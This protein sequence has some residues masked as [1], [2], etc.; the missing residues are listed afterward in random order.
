MKFNNTHYYSTSDCLQLYDLFSFFS[1]IATSFC[2]AFSIVGSTVYTRVG[3]YE[4]FF[5]ELVSETE[6]EKEKDS[7]AEEDDDADDEGEKKEEEEEEDYD[8]L[9]Y[10]ELDKLE[11]RVLQKEDLEKLGKVVVREKTP[12]GEVI[13]T[14]N[15]NTGSFEY[16]CDDKTIKYMVLD[17]VARKF[18]IDNNCKSICINYKAEFEKARVAIMAE[19]V[20]ETVTVSANA[21]TEEKEKQP[22]VVQEPAPVKRSI[23]AR[24]K[25][26]NTTKRQP[27]TE[28][29]KNVSSGAE[30]DTKKTE[31]IYI[32]TEKANRFTYKGRLSDYKDPNAVDLTHT[33]VTHTKTIDF[34]TF[35]QSILQQQ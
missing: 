20:T 8:N 18:T 28:V 29:K 31:K 10:D 5:D 23:Y 30:K 21:N 24:F 7:D 22:D 4:D 13:M 33:K 12:K 32:L 35:K 9:Y 19:Q 14:Y 11:E 17:T 34:A 15:S 1:L 6:T 16:F 3:D 2:V 26:Y 27:Q 25:N